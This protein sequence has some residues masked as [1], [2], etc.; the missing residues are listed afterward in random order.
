M[1]V[2]YFICHKLRKKQKRLD[3]SKI[4]PWH[5][6]TERQGF[7][8]WVPEGTTVFETA[9]IDHSGTSPEIIFKTSK[10]SVDLFL[11]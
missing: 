2:I 4:E 8:P 7:E 1:G 10:N 11:K 9:P 6:L 3:F 5:S